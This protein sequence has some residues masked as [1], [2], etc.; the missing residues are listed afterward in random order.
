MPEPEAGR[1][2]SRPDE[3][4]ERCG[5]VRV[6]P[7]PR[8]LTRRIRSERLRQHGAARRLRVPVMAARQLRLG[9]RAEQP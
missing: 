2:Y 1:L 3:A 4:A 6:L 8:E 5:G 7:T 9:G